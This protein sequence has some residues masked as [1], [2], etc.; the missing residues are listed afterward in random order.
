MR[1]QKLTCQSCGKEWLRETK[2]GPKPTSCPEC[3]AEARRLYRLAH[4]RSHTIERDCASCGK[5]LETQA[6]QRRG[7]ARLYCLECRPMGGDRLRLRSDDPGSTHRITCLSCGKRL[8]HP[9]R[10]HRFC[11][12]NC[13][14]QHRWKQ[15]RKFPRSS[16]CQWCSG[17][18]EQQ[19]SNHIH[20]SASC[21]QAQYR[22]EN[23]EK[24][25][26]SDAKRAADQRR[27]AR[28]R[29]APNEKVIARQVFERDSWICGVCGDPVDQDL[30]YPHQLSASLDH[31]V[32]LAAGGHHTYANTQLSHLTCNIKKGDSVRPR[33]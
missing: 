9:S 24:F 11:D 29:Q 26:Y 2:R 1:Q 14:N 20:C 28:R 15:R 8:P 17:A 18:Y 12:R 31:I 10:K 7:P 6:K 16:Q 19:R 32:P 21:Y 5:R 27:R 13:S 23:P 3:K 22:E 25:G 30:S 33:G 4:P